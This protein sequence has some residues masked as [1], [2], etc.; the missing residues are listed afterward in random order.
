MGKKMKVRVTLTVEVD[1]DAYRREYWGGPVKDAEVRADA[2]GYV[3]DTV[4]ASTAEALGRM[5]WGK[6]LD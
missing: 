3:E 6:V 5:D 2:R 1:V 4:R